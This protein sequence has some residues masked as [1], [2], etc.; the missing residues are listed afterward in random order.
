LVLSDKL[1]ALSSKMKNRLLD[2]TSHNKKVIV[3]PQACEK[4]Y[5]KNIRDE[6]IVKK[7]SNGFN[8]L[9]TGNMSP[10]Q[11]FETI[12]EAARLLKSK[13]LT[14]I[15]WIMVG[16]GMSRGWLEEEIRK[17]ELQNIF[18][19]EGHKAIEEIPKYTHIA[20]IL[21]GC[22]VKSSFLEAT[23]PGKVMSYIAAGRP[24]VLAMDGEVSELINNKIKCGFVGPTEDAQALAANI[25]RIY[26][27]SPAQ[28]KELGERARKYHQKYLERN[29]VLNKLYNFIFK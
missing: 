8:I 12:L 1:I 25:Q 11:S 3:L 4:V 5:E 18:Y 27:M 7:F 22:L 13:G 23:I 17:K 10:A 26:S 28:R 20:D 15:N 2:S 6:K 29:V 16:D 19:F 14:D 21:V 9:F 24:I